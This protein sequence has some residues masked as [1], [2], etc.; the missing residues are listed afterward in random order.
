MTPKEFV[1]QK[2]FAV[3]EFTTLSTD[4]LFQ[5]MRDYKK[6]ETKAIRKEL[7]DL[8]DMLNDPDKLGEYIA[9]M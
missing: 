7:N 5:L 2:G 4:V 1:K 9:G 8:K 6:Q 3:Y